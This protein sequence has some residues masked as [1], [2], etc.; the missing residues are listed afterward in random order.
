ML[1]QNSLSAFA[2]ALCSNCFDT[3]CGE[4]AGDLSSPLL[5]VLV[6]V[7][8]LVSLLLWWWWLLFVVVVVVG[9]ALGCVCRRCVVG[10]AAPVDC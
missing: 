4:G 5:L 3:S 6:L 10:C 9:C 8:V 7:F 2:N 1:R